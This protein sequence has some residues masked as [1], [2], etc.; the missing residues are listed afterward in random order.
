MGLEL[1]EAGEIVAALRVVREQEELELAVAQKAVGERGLDRA[2]VALEADADEDKLL[3]ARA[4]GRLASGYWQRG[5]WGRGGHGYELQCQ[6][7][8]AS[9]AQ[10]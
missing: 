5:A 10:D 2:P 8:S 4:A 3:A 1:L 6:Y 9:V 7:Q